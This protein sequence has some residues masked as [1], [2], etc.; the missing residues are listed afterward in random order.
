MPEFDFKQLGDRLATRREQLK[1]K[2][3]EVAEQADVWQTDVSNYERG[4]SNRLPLANLARIAAALKTSLSTLL[5]G[6]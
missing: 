2:Q 5:R 3:S 1:L 4:L 6:M